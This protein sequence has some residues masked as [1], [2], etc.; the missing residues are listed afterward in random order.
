VSDRENEA[1][2]LAISVVPRSSRNRLEP[3]ADG[4]WRIHVTA[5]PVDGAANA[6]LLTFLASL[7]HVPPSHLRITAGHNSRHKRIRVDGLPQELVGQ[8]L[9]QAL[10]QQQ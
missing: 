4:N 1:S 9:C 2:L 5:P 10:R 6:M 3:Q 8:R 7:L